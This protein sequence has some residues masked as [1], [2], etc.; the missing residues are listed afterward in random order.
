MTVQHQSFHR[1]PIVSLPKNSTLG[2]SMSHEKKVFA[3]LI[4]LIIGLLVTS[5]TTSSASQ[6]TP[7]INSTVVAQAQTIVVELNQTGTASVPITMTPLLTPT[8]LPASLVPTASATASPISYSLPVGC[9]NLKLLSAST[10]AA[11]PLKAGQSF[12]QS[13]QVENNGTCNWDQSYHL[14]LISGEKLG[15]SPGGLNQVI[16]PGKSIILTL[17][18]VA[19][20]QEGVYN[21][22]W[23]FSDAGGT[24][25]GETLSVSI[26][27]RNNFESTPNPDKP[28][29]AQTTAYVQTVTADQMKTWA[30][31]HETA[32]AQMTSSYATVISSMYGSSTAIAATNEALGSATPQP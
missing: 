25:F 1:T 29:P 19:P 28:N 11:N 32:V 22:A 10:T 5:C 13:W 9:N 18:L 2:C 12:T 14:V 16:A 17:D 31:D 8:P 30:G 15:A 21:S 27:V 26:A 3:L 4:F 6:L 7:D 20:S 23:R 24:L